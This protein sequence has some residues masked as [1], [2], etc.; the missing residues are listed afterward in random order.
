MF[1][2]NPKTLFA[3]AIILTT[4]ACSNGL[5]S[6]GSPPAQIAG[7]RQSGGKIAHIVIVMQEARSFD[8]LFCA[9]SGA[10][11]KCAGQTIPLEAK[12]TLS[13]TFQDFERDRK[14]GNFAGERADCP[15]YRRPE[16]AHAPKPEIA[17][18]Y[19]IA[20]Q[21]ALGDEMFSSTGNPTFEAHQYLIA[22]QGGGE[23]QP[24]ATDSD[25]CVYQQWVRQFG[26]GKAAACF[27]YE[28][29]ADELSAAGLSSSYYRTA[30]NQHPIVD[31]WDAFGW[32]KSGSSGISPSSQFISDVAS[33]KLAS[34]T[35]VTPAY[36]DSDLSGSRSACGP[37]WVASVVNAVGESQFWS[38]SAIVVLW[39]GFGGWYDHVSPPLL[40]KDGLG[41]RVPVLVVSPY[42]RSGYVDHVQLE[43]AS[44]LR[45][46]EDSF[47]LEQLS[48]SDRRARDLATSTLDL[49]QAPRAFLR[50][51]GG[52]G[53]QTR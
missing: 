14:S 1:G 25:G 9:Y 45:F 28:T 19:E 29:L 3:I 43:T 27:A 22:A 12:C 17:P 2:F 8:N 26:G 32:I 50:I 38:S 36:A 31:T 52:P 18:Y 21:Y 20:R 24:F 47:G 11:G 42:A 44:A 4:A 30:D 7:G 46:V 23:N 35:W 15:G 41:F 37:Q 49:N 5:V 16:Y 6:T 48:A 51:N 33:G 13:D 53:C 34:V 40:D 39:S 10:D